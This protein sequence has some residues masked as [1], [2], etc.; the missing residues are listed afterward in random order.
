[1][2]R[3][4]R[5]DPDLGESK[6]CAEVMCGRFGG[7]ALWHQPRSGILPD[8]PGIAPDPFSSYLPNAT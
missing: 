7:L 5:H 3:R 4:K 2:L 6:T 8:A 1:L